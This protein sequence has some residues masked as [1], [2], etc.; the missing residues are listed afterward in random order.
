MR[1][2]LITM[3]SLFFASAAWAIEDGELG[4]QVGSQVPH[5]MS[6]TDQEG[7]MRQFEQYA[8]ERGVALFFVRSVDWCPFCQNQVI[9]VNAYA[10][11]F[12]DRGFEPVTLSYDSVEKL[13]A[14]SEKRDASI[15][16]L[17]D[18]ESE[19]IDA[20]GVRNNRFHMDSPAYGVPHPIVFLI[21]RDG[22]IRGKLSKDGYRER[23]EI[24]TILNTIDGLNAS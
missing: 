24:N 22:V 11:D 5:S 16:M 15:T 1:A 17:S 10:E 20:F 8:G 3:A 21:D 7:R 9:E 18:P 14:F 23:P 13:F 2:F 19:V 4:P 12:R 6:L